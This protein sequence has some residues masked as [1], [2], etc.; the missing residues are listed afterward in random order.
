MRMAGPILCLLVPPAAAASLPCPQAAPGIAPLEAP[1]TGTVGG[2]GGQIL[3]VTELAADGEGSLRAALETCGPRVIVF[4]V[5]GVIDLGGQDVR[6]KEPCVT[7]AGETAPSPGITL[8]HGGLHVRT[9]DVIIRH[10]RVRIGESGHE[11]E[12]GWE[13]DGLGTGVGA[14][15]VLIENC[16]IS[17]ATDENLSATGPRFEGAG[18][19]DW[20]RHTSHRITFR[21]NIVAEGLSHSTHS[22]GE[23][24]KGSLIHDNVCDVAI[25]GNL[26]AHNVQRNPLFKGGAR[27]LVA[28]N[29]IYDPGSRAIHYALRANEWEGHPYQR[30]WMAVVGNVL[31]PGLDTEA[32]LPLLWID[33]SG[34]LDL[35]LGPNLMLDKK[36]RPASRMEILRDTNGLARRLGDPPDWLASLPLQPVEDV[37]ESV[38]REAGARPWDRDE[39]D[40]RIV[41]QVR[42]R[43]GRIIDSEAEVGGYPRS[44][45]TRQPFDERGWDPQGPH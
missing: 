31:A 42:E 43:K 18:P 17:W 3:R 1:G 5:G 19:D 14:S 22:K 32:D 20:R 10:L 15:D 8:I 16:S 2:K 6:V 28:N 13:E 11:K 26:Y 27:G 21:R 34:P 40:R 35:F 33:G 29:L 9:H 24:S 25:I 12:S 38:L 45:E 44:K 39:I 37:F 30:G 23:H 36:G 41:R 7:I 4:E